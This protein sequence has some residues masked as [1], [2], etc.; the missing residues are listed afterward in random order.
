MG[1]R[2]QELESK[3]KDVVKE[4]GAES[5]REMKML[6]C[7]LLKMEDH[8]LKNASGFQKL[9]KGQKTNFLYILQKEYILAN[10]LI[11]SPVKPISNFRPSVL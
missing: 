9:E 2:R 3:K 10:T 1:Q 8:E 4:A 7:W 5:E 11:F 6:C